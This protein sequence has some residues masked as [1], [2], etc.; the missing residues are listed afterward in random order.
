MPKKVL[1]AA[2]IGLDSVLVE[3]EADVSPGLNKFM[4]VGLPDTVVQEAK[5]RVRA[6][7]FNSLDFLSL[8]P[9]I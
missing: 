7:L 2:T 8:V 3:V 6:A 5:E 4:V 1:T 9:G